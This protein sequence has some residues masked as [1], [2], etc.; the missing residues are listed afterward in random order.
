MNQSAMD[1]WETK[2][3]GNWN[4][5]KGKIKEKWGQ[6]TDDEINQMEGKR[7]QLIGRIQKAYGKSQEE[8]EREV[9]QFFNV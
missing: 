7:D 6:L 3:K 8:A 1:S 9:N 4:Q 2:I 5:Y